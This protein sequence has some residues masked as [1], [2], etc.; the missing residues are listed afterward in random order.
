MTGIEKFDSLLADMTDQD[1]ALKAMINNVEL[2][3]VTSC[4][5]PLEHW[6]MLRTLS[7]FHDLCLLGMDRIVLPAYLNFVCI[8]HLRRWYHI[9]LSHQLPLIHMCILWEALF[10]G[11]VHCSGKSKMH[12][13]WR[14]KKKM[15]WT[16]SRNDLEYFFLHLRI[17][18]DP[19]LLQLKT[20]LAPPISIGWLGQYLIGVEYKPK[21][22]ELILP[23]ILSKLEMLRLS[24]LS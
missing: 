2:W 15:V 5:F 10:V 11:C 4:E 3:L 18:L 24:W 13:I 21:S 20:L 1:L 23:I 9:L 12:F 16:S 8:S 22:I 14:I 6:S 7:Y 17:S 19:R